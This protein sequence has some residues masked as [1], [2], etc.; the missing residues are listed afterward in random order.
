MSM[1]AG[2]IDFGTS[3]SSVG[4][5]TRGEPTLL[6]FPGE[7]TS[8][9]S[10]IFYATE[11]PA[12]FFGRQAVL[13]Y[14][15][16]VDGRLMRSLKSILGSSLMG[17]QT[18]LGNRRLAFQDII[19]DFFSFLKSS[20]DQHHDEDV[21]QVVL[22]RP[23][24]FVDDDVEQDKLAEQQLQ[25]I[26]HRAG[27]RHVE[28]QFEPVAAALSYEHSLTDEQLAMVV[29][30]GG[31][32]ADF[33]LV[34][35]SPARHAKVDRADDI[36]STA[37]IHIGGTD[38]D[39]QLNLHAIAPHL[40]MGTGVKGTARLLPHSAYF[41]L[42]TWHRIPLLYKPAVLN[43]LRQIQLDAAEPDKVQLLIDVVE[44][45][46]GHALAREV[47]SVK[48]ALSDAMEATCNLSGLS[49][50]L[51]ESV[52]RQSFEISIAELADNLV[53]CVSD[54]ALSAGV[55]SES[56]TRVFYTGGTST[57]PLLRQR[58]AALFSR[59]EHVKGDAFGSVGL[60]LAIDAERRFG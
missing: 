42:A 1:K 17:E 38:L 37:G 36:L 3:N 12:V 5:F 18:A 30:I 31:G 58:L 14:T 33:T 34:R 9:P 60:G 40:G 35:L 26:A 43:R 6:Q 11:D 48:I 55:S 50:P 15:D 51:R 39:R 8:V 32:T 19:L 16:G 27:F 46:L 10:A 45:R 59:A 23:V 22:G 4:L 7:G 28:F 53:Q 41:D 29:D 2:G 49:S 52:T 25:D 24:H 56:V 21:E 20:I 47:E 44:R 57:V 54:V 13:Q